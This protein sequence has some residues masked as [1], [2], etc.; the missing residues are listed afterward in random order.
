MRRRR[1]PLDRLTTAWMLAA[2][3]TSALVLAT[4][5]VFPQPLWTSLHVV[6]LGVLTSAVLQWSWYFARALLHLPATD[7][8]SGRD[9]A[10]RMVMFQVSLVVLVLAMWSGNVVGTVLGAGA[11]GAVIAWHGLALTRAARTRMGNRFAAVVRYYVA[12]AGFLVVGCTLAGFLSVAMF[13]TG[14]PP[15]LLAARDG[16]TLA[17]AVV[18]V[19]GWLGLSILGTL[20]TLGPTM[21]RTRIDPAALDHALTALPVLVT[22]LGVAATAAVVG[23]LPGVGVGLLGFAAAALLGVGLPLGRAARAAGPSS[24]A[25]WTVLAGLCWALVALIAVAANAFVVA[26][27]AA[28]REA[29][30]PWVVLLGAGGVLQ[31]LVGALSYLMPVVIGGGPGP[32]RIGMAVLAT[33]WPLRVALRATTLALLAAGTAAASGPR[34]VWWGLLLVAYGVDVTLLAV[35]GVRQAHARRALGAAPPVPTPLI[36]S[37]TPRSVS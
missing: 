26:D 28:L 22:G 20:V 33:A 7:A 14:A 12:A 6:T 17:H 2:L 13:S 36:L 29:N 10:I 15:W 27:A 19:G 32:V 3:V 16:L 25:T 9:A 24:Y 21:L 1:L 23:W 11:I 18:N 34:V 31:V 8:R 30:L 35:A 5:G 37:P 4:R